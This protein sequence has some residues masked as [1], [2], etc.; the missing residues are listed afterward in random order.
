MAK[1]DDSRARNRIDEQQ[2]LSQGYLTGVQGQLANQY[3]NLNNIYFGGGA[4][5]YGSTYGYGS[6]VPHFSWTGSPYF[7]GEGTDTP[8]PTY[9]QQPRSAGSGSTSGATS[10][11]IFDFLKS[12][13]IS[14]SAGLES[15]LPEIQRMFPGVTRDNSKGPLDELVIPGE[16]IFDYIR[17]AETGGQQKLQL[18]GGP[19]GGRMG[20][21]GGIIG[22]TFG[23]YNEISNYFRNFAKT[24]GLS[25]VDKQNLRSR[26]YSP[27]RAAYSN[28]EREME[29]GRSLQGGYSPGLNTARARMAREQGQLTSDAAGNIEAA[30]TEMRNRNQLAGAGGMASL[31]G[32]TP[33]M[34]KMFGD[35]AI[36]SMG[37]QLQASNLQ[38]NLGLGLIGGQV[39]AGRLPGKFQSA[40]GNVGS[41]LDVVGQGAGI[42][43]PW[44]DAFSG[45]SGM[46]GYTG[47]TAGLPGY[48][49]GGFL[50]GGY[51]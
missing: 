10:Q 41:A 27:I 9:Y 22:D 35:Q 16:G 31:Y 11:R 23:D 26:A 46:E 50:G 7:Q 3:G 28:A 5:T 21:G 51:I 15:A 39:D 42:F 14:D 4:P 30:I 19:I 45:P 13:G 34:A 33:A 49:S 47:P 43:Y 1:G 8:T 24:G 32:T 6:T 25:E 18:M 20:S 12:R 44:L 29:R 38:N 17:N 48:P 2:K 36:A 37:Q 40:M